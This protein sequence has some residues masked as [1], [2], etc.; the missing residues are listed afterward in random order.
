MLKGG[1]TDGV[2]MKKTPENIT[3]TG[4]IPMHLLMI[5]FLTY[6]QRCLRTQVEKKSITEE[7]IFQ[8]RE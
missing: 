3:L 1:G 7:K 6:M 5:V 4:F 2:K 8:N